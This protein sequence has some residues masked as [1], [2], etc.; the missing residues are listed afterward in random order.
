MDGEKVYD[1][2][3]EDP[4]DK[5]RIKTFNVI[6]DNAISAM[7][8]RFDI[9]NNT[10]YADLCLLDPRE[11]EIIVEKGLKSPAL[12]TLAE[13]LLPFYSTFDVITIAEN[14]RLELS[15]LAENWN[16]IQSSPLEEYEMNTVC[17]EED[18]DEEEE[19]L[20]LT[21][22]ACE[23]S[24]NYLKNIKTRLRS[25][26]NQD[27]L[28]TFMLMAVESDILEQIEVDSVIDELANKS[29]I[30]KKLLVI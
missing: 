19:V 17:G 9:L 23:R 11:F 25:K 12:E 28:E 16:V 8:E 3:I 4:E 24:F 6:I 27:K 5:Y 2:I 21:D 29:S 30:L 26:M 20:I 10:F 14:L 22:I 1:H 7:S 13:K 15:K 18:E